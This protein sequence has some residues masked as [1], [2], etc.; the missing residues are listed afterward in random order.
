MADYRKFRMVGPVNVYIHKETAGLALKIEG[1]FRTFPSM[2]AI[3][4]WVTQNYPEP[5]QEVIVFYDRDSKIEANRQS[6]IWSHPEQEWF[7]AT[8]GEQVRYGSYLYLFNESDY[9]EIQQLL[10][11]QVVLRDKIHTLN[12]AIRARVRPLP[13]AK[14]PE[15]RVLK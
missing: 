10:L 6:I 2:S 1:Y 5:P 13:R 8:T 14:V 7:D 11:E 12:E 4:D 3:E 15:K 9:Q